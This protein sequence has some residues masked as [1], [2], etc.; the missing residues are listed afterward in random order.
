[1]RSNAITQEFLTA[2][3]LQHSPSQSHQTDDD[4]EAVPNDDDANSTNDNDERIHKLQEVTT[5]SSNKPIGTVTSHKSKNRSSSVQRKHT[6]VHHGTTH[7][8]PTLLIS[9]SSSSCSSS[10]ESDE[11]TLSNDGET[12]S[13]RD[14]DDD[15]N[16]NSDNNNNDNNDNN[17]EKQCH[18]RKRSNAAIRVNTN[19]N[20]YTND[21]NNRRGGGNGRGGSMINQRVTEQQKRDHIM[22]E[23][24]TSEESYIHQLDVLNS[25]FIEPMARGRIV[26]PKVLELLFPVDIQ[27]IRKVNKNFY[28]HLCQIVSSKNRNSV[29]LAETDY[30]LTVPLD[31]TKPKPMQI[32][33]LFLYFA[34]GFRLY[35]G[36]ITKYSMCT[37]V[38]REEIKRPN[39]ELNQFLKSQRNLLK[40]RGEKVLNLTDYLIVMVQR[41]PRYQLL[42]EDLRRHTDPEDESH[43]TIVEATQV[44]ASIAKFCN[45]KER[46]HKIQ[47]VSADLQLSLRVK[48]PNGTMQD[49]VQPS[50]QLIDQY[51]NENGSGMQLLKGDGRLGPCDMYIFSD[52]IAVKKKYGANQS[53]THVLYL[54]ING[55]TPFGQ[56]IDVN[57]NVEWSMDP[58]GRAISI[59]T[60][61]KTIGSSGGGSDG[62]D[63]DN[64]NEDQKD[65]QTKK[66]TF[67]C[68]SASTCS[69]IINTV[70]RI[71]A[72]KL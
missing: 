20:N 29:R 60:T 14:G 54:R 26:S 30:Q 5:T 65:R 62:D 57:I 56:V 21:N 19:N 33:Q 38:L 3:L 41:L 16:N 4:E 27:I 47:A 18:S 25:V 31:T 59:A 9:S 55:P 10:E 52:A 69:Q 51:T 40:T 68:N 1:M 6:I 22:T 61:Y 32:A 42:M 11:R 49:F 24:L 34:Q 44:I 39:H 17:D 2:P 37:S 8:A 36:Y 35:T 70:N 46:E 45:D 12:L 53:D 7:V 48:L 66:L 64:N 63:N 67:V 13:N 50:R 28:A 43:A 23:L 15:N 72:S 58:E 71:L